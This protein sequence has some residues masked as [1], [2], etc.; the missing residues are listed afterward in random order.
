MKTRN[1]AGFALLGCWVPLS[2]CSSPGGRTDP[3]KQLLESWAEDTI[4]PTYQEFVDRTQVLEEKIGVLCETASGEALEE[5]KAAWWAAREPWKK[6]EILKFGP[7]RELSRSL[8]AN[9]DFWPAR[10]ETI[11]EVLTGDGELAADTLA[12]YGAPARG[13]PAI[14]ALL[15]RDAEDR[16]EAF[17]A[18][19][20]RCA[21]LLALGEDTVHLAETLLDAWSP[22]GENYAAS[23][24]EPETGEFIDLRG[25]LSEVVNRFAFTL[26]NMRGD[27]LG[28][29]LGEQSGGTVQPDL[30]ESRWS[31]RSVQDLKDNLAGIELYYFGP[32]KPSS[33][34]GLSDFVP[35]GKRDWN[36]EMKQRLSDCSKVLDAI[37]PFE[38]AI[39]ETPDEVRSAEDCLLELQ[40]F[41]QVDLI[42]ELGLSVNLNDN[43]GD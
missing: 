31:S 19:G 17:D 22:K 27:K 5:A 40:T 13:M 4:L 38:E 36:A 9:L 33:A 34:L 35:Q 12:A 20:R 3:R 11:D 7:Y 28:R 37:D 2:G 8:G 25:A 1:I 21:Y 42:G 32:K 39:S 26:E 14:E 41:I 43:D 16:K 10:V 15:Y 23:L 6:N 29:P 18:E 24:T 30:I